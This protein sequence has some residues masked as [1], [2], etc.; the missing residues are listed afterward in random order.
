MV[1]G[2]QIEVISK[3]IVHS[4]VNGIVWQWCSINFLVYFL[5]KKGTKEKERTCQRKRFLFGKS[6]FSSLTDEAIL[7]RLAWARGSSGPVAECKT[8]RWNFKQHTQD[9][10]EFNKYTSFHSQAFVFYY[11]HNSFISVS[12]CISGQLILALIILPLFMVKVI[13]LEPNVLWF[14]WQFLH[15]F[16]DLCVAF[17]CVEACKFAKWNLLC[18]LRFT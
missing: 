18:L 4:S 14:F 7:I 10:A 11:S 3:L 16:Y 13:K 2:T 17:F 5:K 15:Y 9:A 8:G 12:F 6:S 1:V